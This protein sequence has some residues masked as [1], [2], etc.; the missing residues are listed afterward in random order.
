MGHSRKNDNLKLCR[1]DD[2]NPDYGYYW[3]GN[4]LVVKLYFKVPEKREAPFI[5]FNISF[6]SGKFDDADFSITC[7]TH[8][9]FSE[10]KKMLVQ[11]GVNICKIVKTSQLVQLN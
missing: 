8:V 6:A 4:K 5:V 2:P 3:N 7:L 1:N 11:A 10:K 9:P